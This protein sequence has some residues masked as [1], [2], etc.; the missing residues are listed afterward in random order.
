MPPPTRD[1]LRRRADLQADF[2]MARVITQRDR[3]AV[4]AA[5]STQRAEQQELR[6]GHP[7]RVPA[8]ARV[9]SQAE[10]VAAGPVAQHLVGQRQAPRRPCTS[11]CGRLD[12]V[13]IE[14][15]PCLKF[16]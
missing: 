12:T 7:L 13:V 3:L 14:I 6:P 10:Q 16:G 11:R 9:L 4:V 5:N 2:P 15:K 1:R 8:H